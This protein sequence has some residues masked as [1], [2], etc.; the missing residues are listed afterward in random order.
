MPHDGDCPVC[1]AETLQISL[2]RNSK[3]TRNVESNN[4]YDSTNRNI[5]NYNKKLH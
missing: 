3:R 1:G 2:R 4:I 5:Y